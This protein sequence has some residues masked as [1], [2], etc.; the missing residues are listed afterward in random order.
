MKVRSQEA[1]SSDRRQRG[2]AVTVGLPTAGR[3]PVMGLRA[4][5]LRPP[6]RGPGRVRGEALPFHPARE[7]RTRFRCAP[8]YEPWPGRRAASRRAPGSGPGRTVPYPAPAAGPSRAGPLASRRGRQGRCRSRTARTRAPPAA[9]AGALGLWAAPGTS[10]CLS[11]PAWRAGWA[12]GCSR[13]TTMRPTGAAG[14]SPG[15]A[16]GWGGVTVTRSSTPWPCFRWGGPGL[17]SRLCLVG[18]VRPVRLNKDDGPHGRYGGHW[19]GA[20]ETSAGPAGPGA[21]AIDRASSWATSTTSR[22]SAA[23][24]ELFL[25]ATASPSMTRQ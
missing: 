2:R 24:P 1:S 5:R 18:E 6:R 20:G 23:S 12:I 22:V 14:R 8:A 4:G 16:A 21:G 17:G 7:G 25:A 11:R 9:W 10:S 15:C 19:S 13:A 3:A